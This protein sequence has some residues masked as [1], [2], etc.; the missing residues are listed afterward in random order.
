MPLIRAQKEALVEKLISELENSRVSVIVAYT[1]LNMKA[2]DTLRTKAFEQSGTVKMISNTLLHLVLTKLGR[3]DFELPSKQLAIAYGFADEVM[4]AK[5]LADFAKETDS[6]EVLAGWIDGQFFDM[7]ALKTLATL[8]SKE[9]LQ[10]QLVGRLGSL[11]G[12][13]VYSLNFPLQKFAYVVEAIKTAQPTAAEKPAVAEEPKDETNE[14]PAAEPE[15]AAE[16]TEEN[17]NQ[18]K[19]TNE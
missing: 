3:K 10:A 1:K 14:A 8:P 17:N 13:L 11:I 4:A 5:L 9:T 7:S 6:L 18:E 12:S 2:N 19:E 16:V 15:V